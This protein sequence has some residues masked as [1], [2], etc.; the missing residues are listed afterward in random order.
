MDG[1]RC[2]HR[3]HARAAGGRA[4]PRAPRA[5][6]RR[7]KT[8]GW[9]ARCGPS[10]APRTGGTPRASAIRGA[11]AQAGVSGAQVRGIGLSG[12]MHGLVILDAGERR[13]PALADLVRSA[14]PAAGGRH[15]R[16]RRPRATSCSY[17]AN[18]VLT[19]FTLPKLLWVRDNEPRALRARPPAAAAQGLRA[20]P[21]HRRIRHAKFPTPPAL[22]CSTWCTGA[23]RST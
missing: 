11:L 12:Q 3:R 22:R 8:S 14:Q 1:N 4:G 10:S 5:S 15:Q 20:L 23:G 18:P 19:G 13:D 6:P 21:P 2:R 7:T 17:T 16:K 9:S